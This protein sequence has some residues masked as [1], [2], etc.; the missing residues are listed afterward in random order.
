M[1]RIKL[2]FSSFFKNQF[3]VKLDKS[4]AEKSSVAAVAATPAANSTVLPG[5]KKERKD[6]GPKSV[7]VTHVD[8]VSRVW[9]VEEASQEALNDLMSELAALRDTLQPASL[10]GLAANREDAIYAARYS[11]DGDLYRVRIVGLGGDENEIGE[12]SG[13]G[14]VEV[15]YIDYGN[16][17]EVE[18]E[19]IYQLPASLTAV[20]PLAR[21]VNIR[22]ARFALD[23]E[24]ARERLKRHLT[25]GSV[26]L[27]GGGRGGGESVLVDGKPL[28]LQ[29][30][31]KCKVRYS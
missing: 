11:L 27:S 9:V 3:V 1:V 29:Y 30:L 20:G 25:E 6:G 19:D 22:G 15:E 2:R 7:S 10:A 24:E 14:P 21:L 31:L 8:T 26:C 12:N 4:K 16:A 5:E 28:N 18:V 17:E 23:T 13:G